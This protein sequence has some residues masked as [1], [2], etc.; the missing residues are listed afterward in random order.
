M[1]LPAIVHRIVSSK[2]IFAVMAEGRL[3]GM[4]TSLKPLSDA[5]ETSLAM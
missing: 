5:I 4:G 2:E 1:T 3:E